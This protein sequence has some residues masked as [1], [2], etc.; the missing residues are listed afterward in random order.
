VGARGQAVAEE[1]VILFLFDIDGTLLHARGSGRG[2][3][4][5]V[6]LAQHGVANATAGVRFGGRT[7][8]SMIDEIFVARLGRPPTA[9]EHTAFLDAYLPRLEAILVE[10]GVDVL[11]GVVEALDHLQGTATL[12]I[13]TGNVRAGADAK[14][15]AA[16]ILERFTV[17]GY[18]CDSPLRAELVGKAIERAGPHDE[19]IVI[20]D[21]IHDISAARAN[22]ATVVAVATGADTA[23]ALGR[24]DVVLATLR[25]L[26]AWLTDRGAR[27]AR[28]DR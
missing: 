3:F 24:A 26:P 21:T 7:D 28:S 16:G 6:M 5:A 22:G 23:E 27:R 20:G 12:G 9:L 10:A 1:E 8:P 14:L 25:E 17:G 13:A 11:P 2:A 19:V 4:D 18:G 15:A